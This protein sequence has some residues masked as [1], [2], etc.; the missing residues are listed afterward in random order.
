MSG[1]G[2][3]WR[4]HLALELGSDPAPNK[5]AAGRLP[6]SL[7][8]ASLLGGLRRALAGI[9]LLELVDATGGVH[10]L[11]LARVEGVEISIL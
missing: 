9:A 3:G 11:L 4:R 10:D 5:K 6:F 8:P 7:A 2:K 1:R